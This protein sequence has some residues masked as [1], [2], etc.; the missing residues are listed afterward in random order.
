ME[1]RLDR[2]RLNL[3]RSKFARER[4]EEI[5]RSCIAKLVQPMQAIVSEKELEACRSRNGRM[6]GQR[7]KGTERWWNGERGNR[8][9]IRADKQRRT[10][11][12]ANERCGGSETARM[13]VERGT[14]CNVR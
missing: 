11:S 14:K 2:K 5:V 4:A 3:L 6:A 8:R 13:Q 10:N 9:E 12:D 1:I 7:G